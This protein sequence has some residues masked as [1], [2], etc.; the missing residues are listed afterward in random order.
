MFASMSSRFCWYRAFRTKNKRNIMK[1]TEKHKGGTFCMD[2]ASLLL[3]FGH[4]EYKSCILVEKGPQ[5][6]ESG[7]FFA[8]MIEI[9]PV[10][11]R[12]P[13]NHWKRARRGCLLVPRHPRVNARRAERLQ[14]LQGVVKELLVLLEV[15]ERSRQVI[16]AE[17]ALSVANVK[18]CFFEYQSHAA[19]NF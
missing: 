15:A 14:G 1:F 13:E 4:A 19:T 16:C 7:V 11:G 17:R 10:T 12:W 2:I 18:K 9:L 5:K 8:R 3:I 6:S